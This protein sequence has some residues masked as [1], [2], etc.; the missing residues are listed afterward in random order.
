MSALD[1]IKSQNF[2]EINKLF[3]RPVFKVAQADAIKQYHIEGHDVFDPVKRPW[4]KISRD[5]GRK[6]SNDNPIRQD[7]LVDVVRVGI[8]WQDTITETRVGFTLSNPVTT[9]VIWD[10]E[11]DKENNLLS[12]LKKSRMTTRWIIRIKRY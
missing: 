1:V 2:T 7:I 9:N 6:D 5:T 3:K 4:R 10:T 12:W 8:S 11:S